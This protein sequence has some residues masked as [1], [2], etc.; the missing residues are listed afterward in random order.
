[1]ENYISLSFRFGQEK[2]IDIKINLED[3]SHWIDLMKD[4]YRF[5]IACEFSI[6][7]KEFMEELEEMVDEVK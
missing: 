2:E 5:L 6:N 3:R 1:M 7:K 4:F